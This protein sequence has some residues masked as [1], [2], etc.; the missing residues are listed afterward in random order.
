M[1]KRR[2]KITY[3]RH[4]ATI[5]TEA[6]RLSDKENYP[7]LNEAGKEEMEAVSQWIK[8]RGVMVDKIFCSP[9]TRVTQSAR[10]LSKV[11][12]QDF[13]II[14]DLT[15]KLSGTWSGL[16]FEQIEEKYPKELEAYHND[17]G[18]FVM[19]NGE[20]MIQFNERTGKITACFPVVKKQIAGCAT[21]QSV[22]PETRQHWPD[23]WRGDRLPLCQ[24]EAEYASDTDEKR[25]AHWYRFHG[26]RRLPEWAECRLVPH[27]GCCCPMSRRWYRK[28]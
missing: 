1:I 8:K 25:S 14:P 24:P 3:I 18:N 20:S 22:A 19:P 4:G 21:S 26:F 16:S 11:C 15:A 23:W 12:K 2:C 6:D 10:I 17:R 9:E 28:R 5:Y 13:E 27:D 7:P